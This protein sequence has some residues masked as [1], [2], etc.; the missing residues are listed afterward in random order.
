M[1]ILFAKKPNSLYERLVCWWTH[2]P[3]YH[4]S[5]VF[6]DSVMFEALPSF[7]VRMV[8]LESYDPA[9][10]DAVEIPMSPI[11]EAEVEQWAAKEVGC[12]YDWAGLIWSQILHIPRS[13]PDKWFCSEFIVDALQQIAR[14]P[15]VKPCTVSPNSLARMLKRG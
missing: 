15:G 8:V 2:G 9:L 13:H 4:C 11:E 12:K 3:Y 5:M 1:K 6:S 10:W 14:F 7:G